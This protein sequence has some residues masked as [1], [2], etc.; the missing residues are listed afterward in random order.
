[1]LNAH[2]KATSEFGVIPYLDYLAVRW[3]DS[4]STTKKYA[5]V[6]RCHAATKTKI[7]ILP[8]RRPRMQEATSLNPELLEKYKRLTPEQQR[9]FLRA[10][11]AVEKIG[12]GTKA[13]HLYP[14]PDDPQ[15][16][17]VRAMLF[18]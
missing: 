1:M 17:P 6:S 4:A 15:K 2:R 13:S 11:R 7:V 3:R 10:V 12:V 5:L 14:D 9:Q 8:K 16:T 18:G